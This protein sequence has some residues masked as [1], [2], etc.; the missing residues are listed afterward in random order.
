[1][2]V[3]TR[4]HRFGASGYL[5]GN[6]WRPEVADGHSRL[7]ITAGLCAMTLITLLAG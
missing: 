7:T 1:M 3:S 5:I 6:L 2:G 4:A